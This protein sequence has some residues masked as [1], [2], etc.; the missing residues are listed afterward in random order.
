MLRNALFFVGEIGG[1][2]YNYGFVQR[3][4]LDE[5]TGLVPDVVQSITD[6]VRVIALSVFDLI[7]LLI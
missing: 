3:K 6:A 7:S 1:N 2:D 4:T 5:L